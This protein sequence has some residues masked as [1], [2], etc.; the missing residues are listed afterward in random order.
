MS[1]DQHEHEHGAAAPRPERGSA[2]EL[3]HAAELLADAVDS[4][5]C[6]AEAA[7]ERILLRHP[8]ARAALLQCRDSYEAARSLFGEPGVD[9]AWA[10]E[11]AAF[12]AFGARGSERRLLGRGSSCIVE[13]IE[14]LQLAR[15]VARKTLLLELG[16]TANEVNQERARRFFAE[17]RLLAA[18]D[19]PGI[20]PVLAAGI[21]ER[22]RAWLEMPIVIGSTFADE[23]GQRRGAAGSRRP[24]LR[25][26]AVLREICRILA[27][28]HGKGVVHRDLKP[29]NVMIGP[30]GEVR[31]L[32]WG[33]ADSPAALPAQAG[34]V[35]GTLAYMAPEQAAGEPGLVG[36][37]SD[38]YAIGAMLY[39]ALAGRPPHALAA[40]LGSTSALVDRVATQAPESLMGRVPRAQLEL[41]A[42]CERAMAR[43]PRDRYPGVAE[44]GADLEAWLDGRVVRAHAVGPLV[45][46]RKWC[47][48]NRLVA[49]LLFSL[50]V[51][52]VGGTLWTAQQSA[53]RNEALR[54]LSD[55]WLLA[56]LESEAETLWPA[57]PDRIDELRRWLERAEDLGSRVTLHRQRHAAAGGVERERLARFVAHLER[58]HGRDGTLA[59]VRARLAEAEAIEARSLHAPASAWRETIAA[60]ADP[61]RSP[62]Y[63]GLCISAQLGL[64]PL[65]PDP[66]SGLYE[67]AHLS[68]GTPARRD[69][70]GHL[71]INEENGIVLVLL[72]GGRFAMGASAESSATSNADPRAN[73]EEG[74]VHEVEL[75][76]FF[77]GKHEL[78]Q[79]QWLRATGREPS[80]YAPGRG[81]PVVDRTHPAESIAGDEAEA[82]LARWALDLPTEAQWEYG[83]RGNLP[84]PF[85][86]A[87]SSGV[88]ARHANL[89]DRHAR[90]GGGG[91]GWPYDEALDDGWVFHAPIGRFG[92]N[93]FGLHDTL[94]NVWEWCRDGYGSYRAPTR[95]GDGLR[96]DR[97]ARGRIHRGGSFANSAASARVS[98]RDHC[99]SHSSYDRIGIRAAR[100]LAR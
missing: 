69:A 2:A 99:P 47:G 66:Q 94:G 97:N 49:A 54:D 83:A 44:L 1:D 34:Q 36:P 15:A 50:I 75:A 57:L 77:L 81:V 82:V 25:S 89:A 96:L 56:W 95:E 48:R 90:A 85:G 23:L 12:A 62:R 8:D 88:L 63:G 79:A 6:I 27:H 5:G 68:S 64:V 53:L 38:Q 9:G 74:P 93:G 11:L 84:G 65:G 87:E 98:T 39:H 18:L 28:A 40:G 72:P 60:I 37:A 26:V 16:P 59:S 51:I 4:S 100:P 92:A 24:L 91:P 29:D 33:L 45:E 19:H 80:S 41:V 55:T 76:P 46:L 42:I 20:L 17:A 21:D 32:D 67:F 70:N 31:V 61:G 73:A 13:R 35:L 71:Q 52:L 7:F 22:G 43:D 86:G 58:F 3:E 10:S 14:D 78:T 30:L